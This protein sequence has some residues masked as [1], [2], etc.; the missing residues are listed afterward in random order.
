M[1]SFPKD[2]RCLLLTISAHCTWRQYLQQTPSEPQVR[3]AALSSGRRS[4]HLPVTQPQSPCPDRAI[5][6]RNREYRDSTAALARRPP[7]GALAPDDRW[8]TRALLCSQTLL[9]RHVLVSGAPP[10]GLPIIG[11]SAPASFKHLLGRTLSGAGSRQS[12]GRG[13][14][15]SS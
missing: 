3:T 8:K 14:A 15:L 10:N 1:A 2:Q 13:T 9:T 5:R 12:L 6:S 7:P 4:Q 11:P